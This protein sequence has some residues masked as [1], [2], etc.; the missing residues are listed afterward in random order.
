[1]G[2]SE[3]EKEEIDDPIVIEV[4][5]EIRD[6]VKEPEIVM[7]LV[8]PLEEKNKKEAKP[9]IK[10]PFSSRATKKDSKEKDFEKF[11]ALFKKLEVNLPFFEALEHMPLYRKFMK[12][13]MTKKRL[14]GGEQ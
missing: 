12:E 4:D 8:K 3:K 7:P 5:L 13:V 14:L 2:E 10:L 11:T 6:N 9:E 1:M